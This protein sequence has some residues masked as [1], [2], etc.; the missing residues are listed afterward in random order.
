MCHE[1]NLAAQN[2]NAEQVQTKYGVEG[3]MTLWLLQG[4]HIK[5]S[6]T[7]V[8][9]TYITPATQWWLH[10]DNK[11]I[12]HIRQHLAFVEFDDAYKLLSNASREPY[13]SQYIIDPPDMSWGF[14]HYKPDRYSDWSQLD[15]GAVRNLATVFLPHLPQ[16]ASPLCKLY[17]ET[18]EH[19]LLVD[20]SY[21]EDVIV[22]V[23]RYPNK[24]QGFRHDENAMRYFACLGYTPPS[25]A[26]EW[27]H[28]F[29]RNKSKQW[30]LY[31]D[32][33]FSWE[34]AYTIESSKPRTPILELNMP[35]EL[36]ESQ[37][38]L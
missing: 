31:E 21:D 16:L 23:E 32:M 17:V 28:D 24:I 27:L 5:Q 34:D 2:S 13:I 11:Y 15:V 30:Q 1:F 19:N 29:H 33:G 37:T 7:Q 36:P 26:P 14:E 35:P 22:T 6:N 10:S 3:L 25:D 12:E 9:S 18:F 8:P 20:S 38:L 4:F